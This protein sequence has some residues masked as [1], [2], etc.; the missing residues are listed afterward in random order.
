MSMPLAMFLNA[1]SKFFTSFITY[2]HKREQENKNPSLL[3]RV[4]VTTIS[5]SLEDS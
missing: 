2:L 1:S 5:V 4:T 3:V